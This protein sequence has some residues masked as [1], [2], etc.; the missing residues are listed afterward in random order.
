MTTRNTDKFMKT[1]A[2]LDQY[3]AENEI[4]KYTT[5]TAG[6]GINYLL[7]HDYKQVYL[8]ALNFLP[9]QASEGGIRILEFGCGGGDESPPTYF[10]VDQQGDSHCRSYRR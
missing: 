4:S 1:N 8:Q 5:A 7:D 3:S 9:Q 2:Y 6:S 10:D